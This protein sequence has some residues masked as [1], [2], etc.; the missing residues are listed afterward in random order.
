MISVQDQQKVFL[1][2]WFKKVTNEQQD[3]LLATQHFNKIGGAEYLLKCKVDKPDFYLGSK[4]K[5]YFWKEVGNIWLQLNNKM[6]I[7][8]ISVESILNQPIFLNSEVQYKRKALLIE[9]LIKQN[10]KWV[11]DLYQGNDL[12]SID[13]LKQKI[14]TYPGFIFDYYAMINTLPKTWKDS[15]KT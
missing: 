3:E 9:P 5:N 15:L 10:I 8:D 1:I 7:D 12:M 6:N 14:Q 4:M 13:T 11:G 2:K